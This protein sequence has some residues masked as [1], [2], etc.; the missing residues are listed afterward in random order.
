MSSFT[1]SLFARLLRCLAQAICRHPKWFVYPQILLFVLSVFYTVHGLK[2]DMSR[3]NL[4]GA[5]KKY[6]QNYLKY[7]QEF[8]GQDE[9]VV[10]VES[11]RS[12]DDMRD[13]FRKEVKPRLAAWPEVGAFNQ[14]I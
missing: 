1:E 9:L 8:P 12:A 5:K 2:L 6:H 10:V 14:Q 7:R 4:V 13:L 3:D 11:M